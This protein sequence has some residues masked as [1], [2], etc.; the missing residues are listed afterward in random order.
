LN[1]LSD[2]LFDRDVANYCGK[3]NGRKRVWDREKEEYTKE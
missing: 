2:I 1:K 3:P